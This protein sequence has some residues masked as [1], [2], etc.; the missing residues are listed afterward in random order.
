MRKK[1][2]I[3]IGWREWVAL[4]SLGI[5]RIKAKIDT[6]ART[7]AL[8]AFDITEA[9]KGK[10]SVVRFKLS[11]LRGHPG[12]VIQVEA[13]LLDKRIVKDSHGRKSLRPVIC[14]TLELAEIRWDIEV[15]L[16]DRSDMAFRMLLGR[17][18]I[19]SRFLINPGKSYLLGR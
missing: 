11:P 17:Q 3:I 7:S 8:H 1:R 5:P 13:P 16:I 4:P 2:S 18:A 6:G 10:K 9:Y 12:K 15:T 19:R 14:V